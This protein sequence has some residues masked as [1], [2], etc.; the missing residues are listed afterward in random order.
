[1]LGPGLG[2]KEQQLLPA[3]A[4]WNVALEPRASRQETVYPA[5][6]TS[7]ERKGLALNR[8][9]IDHRNSLVKC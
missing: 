3:P 1:M 8:C 5:R 2:I 7:P 6:E 4:C 9:G